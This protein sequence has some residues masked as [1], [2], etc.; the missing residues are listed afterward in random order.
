MIA[1]ISRFNKSSFSSSLNMI[2][3]Y[4]IEEY[5]VLQSFY[6][7]MHIRVYHVVLWFLQKPKKFIIRA[8]DFEPSL[9]L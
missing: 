5:F 6:S 7:N 3:A 9:H 8:L 1:V 2:L 4:H